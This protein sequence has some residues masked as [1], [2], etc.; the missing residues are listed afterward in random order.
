MRPSRPQKSEPPEK[1]NANGRTRHWT[2]QVDKNACGTHWD[3]RTT[4]AACDHLDKRMHLNTEKKLANQTA[5]TRPE[6]L[7]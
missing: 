1:R 5:T 7:Q 6:T 3:G 4:L 2:N